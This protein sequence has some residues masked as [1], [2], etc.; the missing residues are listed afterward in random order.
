[1]IQIN[2]SP[3]DGNI[4]KWWSR[5]A[6]LP[7]G[8]W[9]FSF[10]LGWI[11]PYSGSIGA[12]V[13]ELRPGFARVSLRD[14]RKVRNHLHSIHA[15]ALVNLGEI[16]TGLA[17]LSTIN[18]S[19]RGI[20]VDIRA[21]YRKKARGKLTAIAEFQLPEALQDNTEFRVEARLCD[22]SGETVT[23]VTARW[24]LGYKK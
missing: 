20:L 11:A 4:L 18:D 9:L 17:V 8:E 22:R 3:A 13:E 10:A 21:E 15:I 2:S 5:L 14:R 24:L 12:R 6:P 19:M 7:A 16:T 1:M 23:L